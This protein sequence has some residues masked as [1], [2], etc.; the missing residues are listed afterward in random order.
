[1]EHDY[2]KYRTAWRRLWAGLVDGLLFVPIGLADEAIWRSIASPLLLVP[3]FVLHSFSVVAYSIVL[4]WVWGQTLGKRITGVRVLN[5]GGGRLSLRQALLRDILPVSLT[6]VGVALDLPAVS[7]GE[8]PYANANQAVGLSG[9]SVF[10]LFV[11]WASLG[12][13][14]VEVLTMLSNRKRRALHDFI[15]GTVV[16]RTTMGREERPWSFDGA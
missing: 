14:V 10:Q 13:F 7:R 5:V 6:V 1:M 9:L 3:W 2:T 8:N 15:A 11:L 16:V 4:H 12:W